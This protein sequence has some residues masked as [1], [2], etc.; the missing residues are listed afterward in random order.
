M[1]ENLI[2]VLEKDKA[3]EKALNYILKSF[4]DFYKDGK[5]VKEKINLL[6]DFIP[7]LEDV[8]KEK[9]CVKVADRNYCLESFCYGKAD[10]LESFFKAKDKWIIAIDESQHSGDLLLNMDYHYRGSL[11]YGLKLSSTNLKKERALAVLSSFKVSD[12]N[13]DTVKV[14]VELQT[15]IQNLIVAIY[16]TLILLSM[17]EEIYGIFID[18]PLIRTLHPYLYV[19]FSYR[20]L[21]SL[22][23]IDP[24]I[25]KEKNIKN[26]NTKFVLPYLE[27]EVSLRDFA[28]G[29]VLNFLLESANYKSIKE[30]ISSRELYFPRNFLHLIKND[31]CIPGLFIYLSLL[32]ILVD[33]AEKYGFFVAGIV[34]NSN[35]SKEFLRF[36]YIRAFAKLSQVNRKFRIK[37][38]NKYSLLRYFSP[39]HGET[40]ADLLRKG[41]LHRFFLEELGICDDHLLTFILKY[42]ENSANFTSPFEIRRFRGRETNWKEVYRVNGELEVNIPAIGSANNGEQE[43]WLEEVLLPYI[44]PQSKDDYKFFMSYIRTSDLK[45]SLRVEYPFSTKKHFKGFS[46]FIYAS[47]QLYRNYGIPIFMKYVDHLVRVSTNLFNNL[48]K[49]IVRDKLLRE[50]FLGN[51]FD[52]F[53]HFDFLLFN[54]KRDFYSR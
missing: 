38:Y 29:K 48:T 22:F 18:G 54:F 23:Q 3:F 11:A 14:K 37:I 12:D 40:F 33:L 13:E 50:I 52:D 39:E 20:E 5:L 42:S 27:K 51:D 1:R 21:K 47:S 6:F 19:L 30:L 17:G 15:Y 49:G 16:A 7:I 53:E 26:L 4:I 2:S 45:F 34:K 31:N 24:T 35:Y 25:D 36:Y 8:F 41:K 32:R 43:F 44:L 10:I 28:K 9:V 46:S